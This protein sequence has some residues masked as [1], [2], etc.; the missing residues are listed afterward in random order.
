MKKKKRLVYLPL[1][2]SGEI[3]MNM[4]LYGYGETGA[5][6]YILVDIGVTF[7][8]MNTTPGVDLIMPDVSFVESIKERLLGIFITHAHEDHIGALGHLNSLFATTIYC[9]KFSAQ[10]AVSKLNKAGYDERGVHIVNGYPEQVS[11]GPFEVKFVPISHSI[12]EASML[13]IDSPDGRIIHTGDFKIDKT[14]VLGD[15]FD[16]NLLLQLTK[17]KVLALVCD[18]TNVFSEHSGRSEASLVKSITNLIKVQKGV[19]VATTFASNVARLLTLAKC[20]QTTGRSILVLGRAMQTMISN[21]SSAGLLINFP[22]IVSVEEALTLPRSNL[23]ILATGSQGEGR[24]VSAQLAKDKY[25]D[26][27]LEEGDCFL[28]SSKTIPGNEVAVNK[29]INGLMERSIDVIDD[30]NGQYH[31]SGHANRPDL[32][33]LHQIFDPKIVIPMHGEPRH[34]REH[35]KLARSQGFNSVVVPNGSV[36]EINIDGM[37]SIVDQVTVGRMYFDSGS[38]LRS[39]D[40]TVKTRLQMATRGQLSVSL[41][42]ENDAVLE[43]GI[44]VKSK[45][46][47]KENS[48]DSDID[49][50][51]EEALEIAFSATGENDLYDDNFIEGLV[52]KV[53]N[54]VCQ[55]ILNK[56]PV[57]TVFIN[58]L[59]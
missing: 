28:F 17:S 19:V 20:A 35:E 56:K 21:A 34:L 26:I 30:Q 12:P 57:V 31:V 42:F 18:S 13:V 7:P 45:G 27:I 4:Y 23:F 50:M 9:R 25:M 3:G 59:N 33:A 40:E 53:S 6:E 16:K 58:R 55:K 49:L 54:K 38:L 1:G 39:S 24:A 5:E 10:I 36:L 46:L 52:K 2:G 32:I 11:V 29:V 48:R 41:L 14:P 8:D 15:V 44:W 51:L 43:R 47:P 37:A 22:S